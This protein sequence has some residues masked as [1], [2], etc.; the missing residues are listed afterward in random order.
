MARLALLSA[1]AL[2]LPC[3]CLPAAEPAHREIYYSGENSSYFESEFEWSEAGMDSF[4]DFLLAYVPEER[5]TEIRIRPL[6]ES[7]LRYPFSLAFPRG[8]RACQK[9]VFRLRNL[10]EKP[11]GFHPGWLTSREGVV[12]TTNYYGWYFHYQPVLPADG[13]WHEYTFTISPDS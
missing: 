2:L 12:G 1:L 7:N 11:L 5:A 9:I 8:I 4:S 3:L 13:Q 6:R 10:G